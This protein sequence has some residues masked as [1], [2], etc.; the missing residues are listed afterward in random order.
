MK[1]P[2]YKLILYLRK[3]HFLISFKTPT[4]ENS[5]RFHQQ[6]TAYQENGVILGKIRQN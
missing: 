3:A 5:R 4:F 2:K 6:Q 1:Q